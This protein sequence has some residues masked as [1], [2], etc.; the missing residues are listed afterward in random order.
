MLKWC[1]GEKYFLVIILN[2]SK[3]SNKS[4]EFLPGPIDDRLQHAFA[5]GKRHER[6]LRRSHP[7]QQKNVSNQ[8]NQ[9]KIRA[10]TNAASG[11]TQPVDLHLSIQMHVLLGVVWTHWTA[12]E[13]QQE[14]TTQ[15]TTTDGET[16]TT[17]ACTCHTH[18]SKCNPQPVPR[19]DAL[20]KA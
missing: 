16:C 4:V 19:S 1:K 11:T 15:T 14:C 17:T 10:T 18:W 12:P 3:N 7:I 20:R 6:T 9:H 13:P 5:K 2:I 8:P